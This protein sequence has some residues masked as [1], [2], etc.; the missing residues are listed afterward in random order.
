MIILRGA[1]IITFT[2]KC[3]CSVH[4]IRYDGG[5]MEVY[6]FVGLHKAPKKKKFGEG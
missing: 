2:R 5:K 1:Q 3:K 4:R 6:F